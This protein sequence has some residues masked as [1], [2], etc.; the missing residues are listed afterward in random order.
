MKNKSVEFTIKA[1]S[2]FSNKRLR[3]VKQFVAQCKKLDGCEAL[4]YWESIRNRKNLGVNEILCY[5]AGDLVGYLALYHFEE[6]E[7]EITVLTHPDYR[8]PSLYAL[9]WERAKHAVAQYS[10]DITR[11]VFTCNQQFSSLKGYLNRLGAQCSEYTY[12]L[13]LSAKNCPR[14]A[15]EQTCP[16]VLR[17]ATHLDVPALV[18]L[19]MNCFQVTKEVYRNHL[20][21]TL[22]DP[23]KE[24]MVVVNERV[25]VGKLHIQVE[26]RN[27]LLYDFCVEPTEQKKGY[28]SF[29]LLSVARQLFD[30][31]IKTIFVDVVDECDLQ[32]YTKLNFKH[33]SIYEHWKLTPCIDPLKEREK[34]LE[35]LLLNFHCHQVQDQL[36]LTF[37]KH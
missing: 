23:A 34:Q 24:I 21:K 36:S 17:K 25:I 37:Y 1:F 4:F 8:S 35:T 13:A 2:K 3:E 16:M 10:V 18:R 30:R 5:V 32:W 28:G 14:L 12:K 20:L 22:M 33:V 9:L 11:F 7:I 27:V 29:L 31:Q 6:H 26:K 19:E 15:L